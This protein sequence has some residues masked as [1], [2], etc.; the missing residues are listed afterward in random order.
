MDEVSQAYAEVTRQYA[1]MPGGSHIDIRTAH[2]V[3]DVIRFAQDS[4]VAFDNHRHDKSIGDR[5][6]TTIGNNLGVM[7]TVVNNFT[8]AATTSFPPCAPVFTAFNYVVKAANSVKADHD[9]LDSFFTDVGSQLGNITIIKDAI[10]RIDQKQLSDAVGSIYAA[11]LTA[12]A[13]AIR[14]MKKNR[15]L[16]GLQALMSGSDKELAGAYAKLG[17]ASMKLQEVVSLYTLSVAE[18]GR[19]ETREGFAQ[20][21]TG[22]DQ[23]IKG[24]DSPVEKLKNYFGASFKGLKA[25]GPSYKLLKGTGQ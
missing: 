15:V 12:S 23:L 2:S 24:R 13:F 22:L 20:V 4:S 10:K 16:K 25:D 8:G 11:A 3:D 5:I 7:S 19:L 14:Y 1:K 21:Q 17:V 18:S 6:R 9:T